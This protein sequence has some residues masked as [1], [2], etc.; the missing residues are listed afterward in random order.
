MERSLAHLASAFRDMARSIAEH[1]S[2]LLVDEKGQLSPQMTHARPA[3]SDQGHE[4]FSRSIAEAV[5]IDA[6]YLKEDVRDLGDL[7]ER[8]GK[9]LTAIYVTHDHPDHY[10]GIGPLL[11]RFPEARCFA[12]PQVVESMHETMEIQGDQWELLFGDTCVV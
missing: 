6:L 1:G 8:T 10:L 4:T 9:K 3:L 11:E 5:L 2:V 12:L 7:I